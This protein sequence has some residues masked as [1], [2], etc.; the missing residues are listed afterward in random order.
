MAADPVEVPCEP[1]EQIGQDQETPKLVG[2]EESEAETEVIHQNVVHLEL[3]VVLRYVTSNGEVAERFLKFLLIQNHKGEELATE[4]LIFLS[5]YNIDV[6]NLRAHSLNLVGVRAAES[7]VGAISFF[8]FV[9]ALYNFFGINSSVGNYAQTS[10]KGDE[11][12]AKR[13]RHHDDGAA[14][15]VVFRGKEKLKVDTYLPVLDML[16]TELSRRLEA[17]REINNLFGFLTDFSTKSDVEIRQACTKFKEHYFED[18]EPEFIDEM[19]QYKYFIL[20]LE[21]AGKKIMPAE[22][23]YKLIIGNMAQS[24]FPNVM[25]AL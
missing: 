19:V 18:I 12:C 11:P 13:K 15:E 6:R 21:D 16:C 20:Q 8:G 4:I 25:T 22:K 17:Y 9:Q 3:T 5:Q 24:T 10:R 1:F 7:C 23:S 14:E 2:A